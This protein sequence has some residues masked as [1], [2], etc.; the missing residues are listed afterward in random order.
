MASAYG[1]PAV[2]L[3]EVMEIEAVPVF[4]KPTARIELVVPTIT[5][6]K[7]IDVAETVVCATATAEENRLSIEISDSRKRLWD[8]RAGFIPRSY[9]EFPPSFQFA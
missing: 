8:F 4:L 6:P 3:I 2:T 1:P 7:T 9:I 5:S